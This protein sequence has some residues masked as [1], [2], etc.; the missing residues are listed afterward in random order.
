MSN[1]RMNIC[2]N[3]LRIKKDPQDSHAYRDGFL[4][5]NQFLTIPEPS[6]RIRRILMFIESDGLETFDPV[7]IVPFPH[8]FL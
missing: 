8:V 3:G 5:A 7:G 6:G 2:L 4:L 1:L